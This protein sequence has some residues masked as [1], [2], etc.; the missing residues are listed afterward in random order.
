M[1]P[2]TMDARSTLG[3]FVMIM[4][5]PLASTAFVSSGYLM[6]D[7]KRVFWEVPFT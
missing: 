3:P 4:P 6:G 1:V 5:C 7:P 2:A